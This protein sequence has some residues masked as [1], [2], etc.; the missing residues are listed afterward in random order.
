MGIA[1]LIGP[2]LFTYSFA[3]AIRPESTVHLPG[4]PFLIA[5]LLLIAA[6]VV[7]HV[8]TRPQPAHAR[9]STS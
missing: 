5:A 1:N 8:A 2:G 4:T 6:M 7:A 3:L 9:Q